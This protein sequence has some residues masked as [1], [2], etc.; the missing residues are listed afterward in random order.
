MH[1][2]FIHKKNEQV[3][4][5]K[6]NSN[7]EAKKFNILKKIVPINHKQNAMTKTVNNKTVKQV[8]GVKN[9]EK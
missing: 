7:K 6:I 2:K 8:K 9:N 1:C 4:V 3:V 5:P